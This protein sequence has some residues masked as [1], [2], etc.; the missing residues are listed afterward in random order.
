MQI[1]NLNLMKHPMNWLTIIFML[2]VAAVG[3][4]LILE[5]LG[6]R[7]ETGS[8]SDG[9]GTGGVITGAVFSGA[10]STVT[11]GPGPHATVSS[12]PAP[13]IAKAETVMIYG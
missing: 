10:G 8:D 2:F 3:G 12:Y 5:A 9:D 4:T 13:G 11:G 7:P 1:V 6:I